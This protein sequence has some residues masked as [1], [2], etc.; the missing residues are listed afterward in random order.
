M[1]IRF[2]DRLEAVEWIA[3]F[4]ENEGQ[5]EVLREQLNFNFIYEGAYFLNIEEEPGEVVSL[6]GSAKG[7][8]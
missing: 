5:F 2:K 1:K 8:K 7:R 3:N 6:D 4:V